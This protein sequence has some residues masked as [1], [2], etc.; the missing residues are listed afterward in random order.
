[1][2]AKEEKRSY[3]S[4]QRLC[5]HFL[6]AQTR[7]MVSVS[8]LH[9]QSYSHAILKETNEGQWLDCERVGRLVSEE[10]IVALLTVPSHLPP[11]SSCRVYCHQICRVSYG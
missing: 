2:M 9:H 8:D 6:D 11:Q 4:W 1:M 5:L 10:M 7:L 3:C